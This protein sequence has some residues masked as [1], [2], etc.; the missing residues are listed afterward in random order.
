MIRTAT[1]LL[2]A[3]GACQAPLPPS[4]TLPP[5]PGEVVILADASASVTC[6]LTPPQLLAYWIDD[7]GP[8]QV[9]ECDR[10]GGTLLSTRNDRHLCFDIDY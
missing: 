3:L 4:D 6:D 9:D 5:C 2:T 7:P 10:S 1:A 8:I